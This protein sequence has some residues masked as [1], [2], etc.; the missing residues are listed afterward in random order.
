MIGCFGSAMAHSPDDSVCAGCRLKVECREKALES[1][2]T[3]SK[4]MPIEDI[5]R[6]MRASEIPRVAHDSTQRVE[7]KT[8]QRKLLP[9]TAEQ[10]EIIATIRERYSKAERLARNVFRKGIDIADSVRNGINPYQHEKSHR[11]MEVVCQK[12]IDH[13]QFS[14]RELR[15]AFMER[16]G[17][18]AK[19]AN[20]HVLVCTHFLTATDICLVD[21][22]DRFVF[23]GDE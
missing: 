14:R 23:R 2:A 4:R 17:W 22:H 5:L 11:Y 7:R 10:E 6:S 19:T 15:Q 16:Y 12:L 9:L 1:A 13:G 3:I 8:K 18:D 20:S 21:M